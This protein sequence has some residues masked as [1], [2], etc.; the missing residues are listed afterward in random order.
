MA[1]L[2]VEVIFFDCRIRYNCWCFYVCLRERYDYF[3]HWKTLSQ[4][5]VQHLLT[6]CTPPSQQI[7]FFC[8]SIFEVFLPNEAISVSRIELGKF[9]SPKKKKN[10]LITICIFNNMFVL[11]C[12]FILFLIFFFFFQMGRQL[13]VLS[14]V[15]PTFLQSHNNFL[16]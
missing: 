3:M 9:N 16:H 5:R 13:L 11:F 12:L 10:P 15:A 8:L 1:L 2:E 4:Y 6:Q 7:L 14:I